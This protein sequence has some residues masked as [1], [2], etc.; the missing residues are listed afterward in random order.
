MTMGMAA[1]AIAEAA[2]WVPTL[3]LDE[4]INEAVPWRWFNGAGWQSSAL[5]HALD[6]ALPE[7]T[8]EPEALA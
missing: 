1:H 8:P 3:S 4:P 5:M 6:P 2:R 7:R